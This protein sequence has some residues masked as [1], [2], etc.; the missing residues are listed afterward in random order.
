[1]H[2][3]EVHA[4]ALNPKD[5]LVRK[6]K[7]RWLTGARLPRVPGYDVAGTLLDPTPELPAGSPVFGMIQDHAGGGC[8]EI[9]SLKPHE[10][11]RA[12]DGVELAAA[13]SLPLAGMTALQA[14]RDLLR[15]G[16]GDVVLLNGAS[17]GVGTLAV[18]IARAL[19]ARVVAVCSGRNAAFVTELGAD[20]VVDYTQGLVL[21]SGRFDCVFDIFG[22]L[23]WPRARPL[24]RK[25]GRYCTAIPRPGAMARE[26][27]SRARL[28]RARLVVVESRREDLQWLASQVDAGGLR[29]VVELFVTLS[30]S[31]EGHRHLETR[32]ARGKVVVEVRTRGGGA[33]GQHA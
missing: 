17:G 19:G 22:T 1:M 14:L 25:T 27:L 6:G 11:A 12:P 10:F 16:P 8:A 31:A 32:R 28:H 7:M 13:A 23:P 15:V 5:V 2:R 33:Y 21:P 30:E 29:P 24:L 18:Q 9:A 3:I 20:E 26:A 4:A